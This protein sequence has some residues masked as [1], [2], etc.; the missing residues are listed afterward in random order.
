MMK[1]FLKKFVE[2]TGNPFASSLLREFSKSPASKPL[3]RP[4]SRIF[5]LD[6]KQMERPL[7]SYISIHD[8]FTRRLT[9]GSRPI[10][11]QPDS[12]T[13][14]VDGVIQ[15]FGKISTDN[16]FLIK[17]QLYNLSELLGDDQVSKQYEGGDY[18]L[19]YLS[20]SHYHRIH[21]PE[22]G[23]LSR[24]WALGE[25]SF[26]VNAFGEKYGEKPFSTNY[27][28]ISELVTDYGRTALVKVGALNINSIVLTNSNPKF[29]KGDEVGYFSFG[30]T[31]LLLFDEKS[32]FI[33][34]VSALQEI[35]M[36][37]SIGRHGC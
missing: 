37:Q 36:G 31:V 22:N 7:R 28:I 29:T 14:P 3:V 18:V 33:P 10:D 4:F 12:V 32:Q 13:S 19:I 17:E 2:L 20:P 11:E 15:T 16:T 8:L 26:P 9:K 5:H 27:R 25:Q 1:S 34:E 23:E 6:E 21:Y 24:R 35:C 30:S